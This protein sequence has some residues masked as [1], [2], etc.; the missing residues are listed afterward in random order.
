[1]RALHNV[2]WCQQRGATIAAPDSRDCHLFCL[3]KHIRCLLQELGR[4]EKALKDPRFVE[5]LSEYAKEMAD[6]KRREVRPDIP[7]T[8]LDVALYGG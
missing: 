1:M 8:T 7:R 2:K 4:F 3:S 6:P 5:M